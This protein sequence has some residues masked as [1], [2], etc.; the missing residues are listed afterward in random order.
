MEELCT[1]QCT[2]S[3]NKAAFTLTGC[4][5]SGTELARAF[6]GQGFDR[7]PG[8]DKVLPGMVLSLFTCWALSRDGE[9]CLF[10]VQHYIGELKGKVLPCQMK[11]QN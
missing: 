4:P 6:C 10:Q 8:K 2:Q 1:A 9:L 11:F 5:F 3:Q 7:G